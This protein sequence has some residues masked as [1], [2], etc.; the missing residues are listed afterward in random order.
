[1]DDLR[2]VQSL[3]KELFEYEKA[4]TDQYDI[5]W[6]FAPAGEKFFSKYLKGRKRFTLLAEAEGHVIGYAAIWIGKLRWRVYN[7]IVEIEN[8]CVA[9]SFRGRGVGTALMNE[10]M[11]IAKERGAKRLRVTA[12]S[13]NDPALRFYRTHGYSD[14]DVILEKNV[15]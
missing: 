4:Y 3:S 12:L 11:R 8:L 13:E 15:T 1:M 9:P 5:A 2:A 10:T 14:V 7:P 6:S